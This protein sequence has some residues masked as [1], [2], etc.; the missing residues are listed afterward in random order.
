MAYKLSLS[1]VEPLLIFPAAPFSTKKEK[2]TFQNNLISSDVFSSALKPLSPLKSLVADFSTHSNPSKDNQLISPP[3]I[4]HREFLNEEKESD[5]QTRY[6]KQLINICN[7]PS[8]NHETSLSPSKSTIDNNERKLDNEIDNY[9][10]DVKYSPYKGQGKTSNPSQ[11]TTKCPGIFEEDNFF[12]VS[13]KRR[14]NLF[15]KYGKTDLGKPARVPS[16]KKSLSSTIKSPPSRV[17]LPTSILSKS[18]PLKVPNKNRSSTFSPLRTPTSSSKT[19]VIVDHSTPSPPSI[20]TKLEAFAPNS[21]FATQK[22][23]RRLATLESSPALRSTLKSLQSKSSPVKLLKLKEEKAKIKNQLFKSEEEKDPVGKQ[24]LPLESS[25]SPLDHSSAEKEMQ[26][27]PAK[28]KRRRTGS[29]ETGLY[30]KESPTPSKKRSKRV[31]WSLKHIV[32]PGNRE[33][34]SLNSTPE[35][36]MKKDTKWPQNL[37]KNNINSEPNTPTKSNI[38][39]GKAHSARAHKT[40]KNIQS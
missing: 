16:P 31:L 38:D 28:N 18:P 2:S 17:K 9:K 29:L 1:A 39:T 34:H 33:K 26:K 8:K 4:N 19:F 24:K 25:L 3:K 13:P 10:H 15:E 20:R 35:S 22:R 36:I 40:R 32:S 27:A 21:T 6:L 14:K 11:G 37:A 30:P 5:T 7:S 12:S 23:L